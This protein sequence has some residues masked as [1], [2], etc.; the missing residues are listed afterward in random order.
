VATSQTFNGS[1]EK[2]AEFVIVYKLYLKI[3]MREVMIEEQV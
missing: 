3:R 2:I 1:S